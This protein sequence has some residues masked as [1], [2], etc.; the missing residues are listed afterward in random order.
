VLALATRVSRSNIELAIGLI[1]LAAKDLSKTADRI[2]RRFLK[3]VPEA[4]INAILQ[5]L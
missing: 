2:Q 1:A 5:T 4:D 3:D